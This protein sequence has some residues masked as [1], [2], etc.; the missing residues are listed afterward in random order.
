MKRCVGHE[1]R[2]TEDVIEFVKRGPEPLLY[3]KNVCVHC[4]AE[5]YQAEKHNRKGNLYAR[6]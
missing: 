5:D 4:G 6:P 2:R 3:R 1:Y